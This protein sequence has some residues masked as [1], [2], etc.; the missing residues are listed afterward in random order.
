MQCFYYT[1]KNEYFK[2][3]LKAL[4]SKSTCNRVKKAAII[5]KDKYIIST[6]YSGSPRSCDHCNDNHLMNDGH[7]IN[8]VHAEMNAIINAAK[9][10]ISI[11][12]CEMYCSNKP[13]FRCMQAL[14]NSGIRFCY[15]FDDY[16]DDFQHEFE[17]NKFCI[18]KKI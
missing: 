18:F 14:I 6:G 2:T 8:T 17:F 5:V 7:C 16:D 12:G 4:S 10:G 3:I 1:M 15:Y 9:L 13:C 11:E